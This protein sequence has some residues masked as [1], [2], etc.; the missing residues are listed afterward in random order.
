[1]LVDALG[2]ADRRAEMKAIMEI[3]RIVNNGRV[4]GAMAAFVIAAIAWNVSRSMPGRQLPVVISHAYYSDDDGLTWFVDTDEKVPPFDHDGKTAVLA[5]VYQTADGKQFVQHLEEYSPT[6]K[7]R[8]ESALSTGSTEEAKVLLAGSTPLVK[9][10]GD[11]IWVSQSDPRA[12]PILS[13]T[14]LMREK[15]I[16]SP[17]FP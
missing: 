6:I 4:V 11:K 7:A 2:F 17:V 9:K 8:A 1:L 3:R 5:F 12:L 16:V 14:D 15:G 10:P 13:I